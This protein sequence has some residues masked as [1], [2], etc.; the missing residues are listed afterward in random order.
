MRADSRSRGLFLLAA[1]ACVLTPLLIAVGAPTPVRA[2]AALLFFCLAPGCAAAVLVRLRS[3]ITEIGLVIA[4]SLAVSTLGAEIML[5]LGIWNPVAAI[6]VTAGLCLLLLLFALRPPQSG[7]AARPSASTWN[8]HPLRGANREGVRRWLGPGWAGH[9]MV[10]MAALALWLAALP[11]TTVGQLSG[12]GLLSGLP[13]TYYAALALLVGG[14]CT[15][16]M[17]GFPRTAVLGGYVVLLILILHGTT[18]VLYPEPR[19]TW[20]YKHFGVIDYI[21][22]HGSVNRDIDIYQN[23]PGFFAVNAWFSQIS[24]WRP[25]NYAAWVQVFFELLNVSA[26]VFALRGLTRQRRHIWIA[27]W[28]FLWANWI[29]QDYLSPQAFG[30]F[31]GLVV[32]GLV[33]RCSERQWPARNPVGHWLSSLLSRLQGG[34]TRRAPEIVD[35]LPLAIGPQAALAL[36][37][38]C[39]L[40]DVIS[41][42]LTPIILCAAVTVLTMARW[43][44]PVWIPVAMS[45]VTLGWIALAWPFV[46]SHFQILSFDIPRAQTPPVLT[47]STTLGGVGFVRLSELLIM[48]FV[49]ALALAEAILEFRDRLLPVAV[50]ALAATPFAIAVVQAYGGESTLRAFLFAL[51][52]LSFLAAAT[53]L[54][55]AR[56]LSAQTQRLEVRITLVALTAGMAAPFLFAYFG[57]ESEN[58]VSPDDVAVNQW[59]LEHAPA[60]AVVGFTGPNSA[61]RLG[62][63]YADM[64]IGDPGSILSDDLALIGH[65]FHASDVARIERS[66]KAERGT[67]RYL[68]ISPSNTNYLLLYG[69]IPPGWTDE[70]VTALR[71]STDFRQV[72]Q[73]G[74]A[75]VFQLTGGSGP[76]GTGSASAQAQT[77]STSATHG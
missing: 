73:S 71:A 23:W 26:L 38:T 74:A 4:V 12:Y 44:R 61:S 18:A 32:I 22:T 37:G 72:Y 3:P 13:F 14:F 19:Y 25:I 42:Q 9:A 36:G 41:H 15:A 70:L 24:G 28:V 58:F 54:G 47:G 68:V 10:F 62:A 63:R 39:F 48:G 40:A 56:T 76:A 30:F 50:V 29:G 34:S 52:W 57:Q 69:L 11:Q 27:V 64:A 33:L 8:R 53:V 6:D 46:S 75:V 43:C 51:P 5:V 65:P 31:E 35:R 2:T 60:G 45:A 1:V 67:A 16:V 7:D 17:A 66:L 21:A 77:S 49:V 20:A 59:Y 55:A